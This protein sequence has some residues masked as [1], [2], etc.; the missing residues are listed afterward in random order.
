MKVQELI[1]PFLTKGIF[2]STVCIIVNDEEIIFNPGDSLSDL[3]IIGDLS[4]KTVKHAYVQE[5]VLFIEV[6]EI[7]KL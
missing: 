3:E 6:K 4:T 5:N 2:D 7:K 1:K